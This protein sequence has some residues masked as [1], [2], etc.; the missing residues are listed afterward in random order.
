MSGVLLA[1]LITGA[2]LCLLVSGLWPARE[3]LAVIL[4]RIGTAPHPR[5]DRNNLDARVGSWARRIDAVDRALTGLDADLGL[6]RKNPDEIAGQLVGVSLVGLLWGPGV[7][8]ALAMAGIGVPLVI[9]V[10][11]A[12]G[13][14]TLCAVGQLASIK[15]QANRRRADFAF[16]LGAFLDVL[17]TGLAAGHT[18]HAAVDYAAAAGDGWAFEDIRVALTNGYIDGQHPWDALAAFATQT[19]LDDLAELAAALSLAGEEGAAVR[20]IVRAKAKVL[21]DRLA[22]GIEQAGAEATERMAIPAIL[23]AFGFFAFW[24]YPAYTTLT[25]AQ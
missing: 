14:A 22:A 23:L 9:P 20:S 8:A 16:A 21:R 18:V 3:P 6:L 2:G 13:G 11:L 24:A 4:G 25:A 12:L 5:V 7:V 17:S 19:R 1:G 10:W 15:S